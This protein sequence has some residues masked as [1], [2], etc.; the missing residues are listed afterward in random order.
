MD[1][2]SQKLE[3]T[4][5]VETQEVQDQIQEL[6]SDEEVSTEES[7]ETVASLETEN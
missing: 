2:A 7:D 3:D 5:M 6:T 4:L 1:E